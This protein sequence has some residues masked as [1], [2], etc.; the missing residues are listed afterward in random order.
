MIQTQICQKPVISLA[1]NSNKSRL[2]S[3]H[4]SETI[5]VWE[6]K[7]SNKQIFKI[8][9]KNQIQNDSVNTI[10][11]FSMTDR[12]III[13]GDQNGFVKLWNTESGNCV[14]SYKCHEF[15]IIDM[16]VVDRLSKKSN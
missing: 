13:S 7:H 2:I 4:L 10:V 14:N 11:L 8:D 9:L 3:V 15:L 1:I 12:E 16:I 6:I 5:N